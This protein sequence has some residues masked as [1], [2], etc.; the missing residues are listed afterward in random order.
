MIY[1]ITFA[2]SIDYWIQTKKF[3]I[4]NV[5]RFV[6][7]NFFPGGKGINAAVILKRHKI[8]NKAISFFNPNS[9]KLINLFL[10]TEKINL[11]N[12]PINQLTRINIKFF[13]KLNN[14]ELNGPKPIINK[15][16][17]KTLLDKL[18][19]LN[20]NDLVM[21]MG[22]GSDDLILKL[23]KFIKLKKA[24]FIID[25]DSSKNKDFIKFKPLV[26]KPNLLELQT[27]YN[28]KINNFSDLPKKMLELQKKGAFNV[29]VSCD[30][31]GAI[32]LDQDG[33]FFKTKTLKPIKVVSSTGAG[34]TLISLYAALIFLN[35]DSKTA[36][37]TATAAAVG[38]VCESWLGNQKLT[39]KN[40]DIIKI[41]KIV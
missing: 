18:Q 24:H 5:N 40:L 38:T 20:S 15:Q 21:I 41:L 36:F 28:L 19:S 29:I 4:N 13:S 34:D 11:I 10:I 2:P 8:A 16:N 12:I 22:T 35:T 17:F 27:N 1:T 37:K 30:K 9:L 14:F 23:I 31:D 26:I 33:N 7:F 25:V 6:D 32:L 39:N 3:V